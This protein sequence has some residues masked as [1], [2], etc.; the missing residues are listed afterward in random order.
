M[1]ADLSQLFGLDR[2]AALPPHPPIGQMDGHLSL[3]E[4]IEVLE[5][6]QAGLHPGAEEE[7]GA[8]G[9]NEIQWSFLH[10]LAR[11][12]LVPPWEEEL[13]RSAT[14]LDQMGYLAAVPLRSD[15]L[16]DGGG[17]VRCRLTP[18]GCKAL[19]ARRQGLWGKRGPTQR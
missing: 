19:S 10:R 14:I 5:E 7:E 1:P 13:I 15:N 3:G 4:M 2:I 11:Q 17:F 8:V 18:K 12:G 6:V 16:R 9:L